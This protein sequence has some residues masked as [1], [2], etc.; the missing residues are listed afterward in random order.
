MN[1]RVSF[2][3]LSLKDVLLIR[4]CTNKYFD[5]DAGAISDQQL[6]DLFTALKLIEL[7]EI[8]APRPSLGMF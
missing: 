4:D 8:Q 3:K 1:I 7:E 5:Q 2:E 6:W